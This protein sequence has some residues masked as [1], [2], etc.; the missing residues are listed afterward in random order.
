[1]LDRKHPTAVALVQE[2]RFRYGCLSAFRLGLVVGELGR[3]DECP[4][5]DERG[6]TNFEAGVAAGREHRQRRLDE[7]APPAEPLLPIVKDGT[8]PFYSA[9]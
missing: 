8:D 3:S 1:M 9:G 4:Y 6:R 5:D 7:E 2:A